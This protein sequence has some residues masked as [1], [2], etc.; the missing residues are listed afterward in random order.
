MGT[1]Q[2]RMFI[3]LGLVVAIMWV[4]ILFFGDKNKEQAKT[5]P[6]QQK[7][8]QTQGKT[9]AAPQA[10]APATAPPAVPAPQAAPGVKEELITV[11][12]PLYQAVFSTRGG[13]LKKMVLGQ[14]YNEAEKQGGNFAVLD[15]SANEPYSLA[16]NLVKGDPN[17]AQR[18]FAASAKSLSV[19]QGRKQL[20]FST[21]VGD[22]TVQKIYTFQ[23]DSYAFDLEVRLINDGSQTMEVQPSLSLFEKRKRAEAAMYAFTGMVWANNGP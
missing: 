20:V 17:L 23:S 11:D 8:A 3:A 4:W 1:D 9:P 15:M 22:L 2:K 13:G 7:A 16:L 10:A 21:K 18:S 19:S 14:Y 6:P 5:P 12:T